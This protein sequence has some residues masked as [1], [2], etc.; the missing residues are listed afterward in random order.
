MQ[1]HP[2]A[3]HQP[4]QGDGVNP[5]HWVAVAAMAMASGGAGHAAASARVPAQE[6]GPAAALPGCTGHRVDAVRG[7]SAYSILRKAG[8]GAG[9]AMH[10]LASARHRQDLRVL[11]AGDVLAFC[12]VADTHGDLRLRSVDVVRRLPGAPASDRPLPGGELVRET[13]VVE[14]TLE[15]ALRAHRVPPRLIEAVRVY[16]HDDADLPSR[17]PRGTRVVATFSGKPSRHGATLLCLDVEL[18][19]R[20]HRLFH[21]VDADGRQYVLGD[22]GHGI[23]ILAMQRP[24]RHARISSGWGWRINPVLERRE[25]HKGIDY[26]APLGT[27]VRAALAGV[28]ETAGWHG[29][30]GRMVDVHAAGGIDTRYGHLLRFATGIRPGAHVGVGQVIGYVGASGLATGPHLYFELWERHRRVN[31]LVRAPMATAALDDDGL[32]RFAAFVGHFDG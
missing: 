31:P 29:N 3:L 6:T 15:A 9:E 25:F 13:L 12:A 14:S 17:L 28:V 7:D 18:H 5:A 2:G 8:V 27:P 4:E 24:L 32:R 1:A 30:Y 11:H 19:G 23:R 10:W 16:L 21:Y 20:R 26:A 22:H